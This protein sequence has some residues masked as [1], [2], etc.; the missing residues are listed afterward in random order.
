MKSFTVSSNNII[1]HSNLSIIKS[2]KESII[3]FCITLS[4]SFVPHN[5]NFR[6]LPIL[7]NIDIKS[8]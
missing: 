2:F 8:I 3:Y 5:S 4:Y 6:S 7:L 1:I